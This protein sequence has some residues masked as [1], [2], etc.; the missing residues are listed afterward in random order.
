MNSSEDLRFIVRR[1]IEIGAQQS[2]KNAVTELKFA[3]LDVEA[4]ENLT[5]S[6]FPLNYDNLR[7]N[8][9]QI[10]AIVETGLEPPE[11]QEQD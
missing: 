4:A 9:Q 6:K 8:I 1:L 3:L 5:G 10:I 7:T 2:Y 11:G